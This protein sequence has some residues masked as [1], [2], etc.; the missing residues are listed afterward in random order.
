MWK[1]ASRYSRYKKIVKFNKICFSKPNDVRYIVLIPW[2]E[3]FHLLQDLKNFFKRQCSLDDFIML[4]KK[5]KFCV[6]YSTIFTK[7]EI[8]KF[9]GIAGKV[10]HGICVEI[11]NE[12]H[13]S[14]PHVVVVSSTP[15]DFRASVVTPHHFKKVILK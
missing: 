9:N 5:N 8:K 11:L 1:E 6:L 3:N 15:K 12:I 14:Y 7:K 2:T 10:S 4:C 13:E